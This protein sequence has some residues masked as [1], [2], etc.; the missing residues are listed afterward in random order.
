MGTYAELSA[1]S[2]AAVDELLQ[3][4][5]PLAHEIYKFAQQNRPAVQ[6]WFTVPPGESDTL[7]DIVDG[8]DT[9]A[10]I[11]NKTNLAGAD[12]V[13]KEGLQTLIGYI[14]A[15]A[16]HDSAAHLNVMLPFAGAVN[17]Q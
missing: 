17:F 8:L 7:A 13:T 11:P 14:S 9:G 5:R 15:V 4:T 1:E 6:Q 12:S 2:Q 16:A 10:L 3:L